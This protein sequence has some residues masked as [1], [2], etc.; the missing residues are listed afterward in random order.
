MAAVCLMIGGA[1]VLIRETPRR[2]GLDVKTFITRLSAE[3]DLFNGF[4]PVGKKSFT[5]IAT[6]NRTR[7]I[8][9]KQ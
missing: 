5:H 3:R 9:L 6:S 2:T 4:A 7:R 1:T 8:L